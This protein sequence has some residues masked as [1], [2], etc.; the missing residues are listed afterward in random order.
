VLR[1]RPQIPAQKL[2]ASRH[3]PKRPPLGSRRGRVDVIWEA[4]DDPP[5]PPPT[6]RTAVPARA[7]KRWKPPEPEGSSGFRAKRTRLENR[8]QHPR[9]ARSKLGALSR[10]HLRTPESSRI[11][12]A[13]DQE[14]S[15]NDRM[16]WS[17]EFAGQRPDSASGAGSGTGPENTLK[18][19]TRVQIPLGLLSGSYSNSGERRAARRPP[20]T[21]PGR[22]S[23]PSRRRLPAPPG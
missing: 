20:R 9:A 11:R 14:T 8:R 21:P 7:A 1:A 23:G 19:E 5:V 2:S 12:P 16:R 13:T 18:V 15:R 3:R 10:G 17:T 22:S 6:S 4:G